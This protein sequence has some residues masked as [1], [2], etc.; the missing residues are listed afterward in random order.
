M[1][2]VLFTAHNVTSLSVP[3][4]LFTDHLIFFGEAIHKICHNK[5]LLKP[6]NMHFYLQQK[7]QVISTEYMQWHYKSDVMNCNYSTE[8]KGSGKSLKKCL[9]KIH[10]EV[11]REERK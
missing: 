1:P 3:S 11:P 4:V 6:D 5:I 8:N 10:S 7:F 2:S 9:T